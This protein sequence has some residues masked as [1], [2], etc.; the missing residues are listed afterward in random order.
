MK[1]Y[2]VHTD[3]EDDSED[4]TYIRSNGEV[5]ITNEQ[6]N[7]YTNI[8]A[9]DFILDGTDSSLKDI[10]LKQ[11]I[12]TDCNSVTKTSIGTYRNDSLNT[13]INNSYG[14]LFTYTG[15]NNT[16][17]FQIAYDTNNRIFKRQNINSQGWTT[18]TTGD[19]TYVGSATYKQWL[20]IPTTTYSELY[21]EVFFNGFFTFN[22]PHAALIGTNIDNI[23]SLFSGGYFNN[24]NNS[25]G[26]HVNVTETGVQLNFVSYGSEEKTDAQLYV[27]YK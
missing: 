14:M 4:V 13:P 1:K 18:W 21:I 10:L 6:S 9:K 17:I 23:K 20:S 25:Y 22:I 26:I 15:E 24:D 12:I 27:Y 19:Y 7:A 2:L 11:N 8:R 5:R 3:N 16:W